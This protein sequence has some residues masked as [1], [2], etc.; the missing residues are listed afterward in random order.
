[1]IAQQTKVLAISP[2]TRVLFLELTWWKE[3]I[4]SLKLFSDLYLCI[5]VHMCIQVYTHTH[6]ITCVLG[7]NKLGFKN[8][9]YIFLWLSV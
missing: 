8:L 7:I 2:T 1:M 4:N 5:T 6:T 3:R 9:H